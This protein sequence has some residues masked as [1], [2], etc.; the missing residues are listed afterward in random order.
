MLYLASLHLYPI[1]A[2]IFE[3][4]GRDPELSR[5]LV[6]TPEPTQRLRLWLQFRG[7]EGKHQRG[8]TKR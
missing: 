2:E 6:T 5:F 3:V 7:L 4:G 1:Q 8:L